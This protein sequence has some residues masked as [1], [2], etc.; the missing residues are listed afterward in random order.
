MVVLQVGY[1]YL[2][3]LTISQSVYICP[4][5]AHCAC[6]MQCLV[7]EPC[8]GYRLHVFDHIM[9]KIINSHSMLSYK[10]FISDTGVLH[11]VVI[12]DDKLFHTLQVHISFSKYVLHQVHDVL[13]HHAFART[14]QYM[15]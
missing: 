4:F 1:T 10:Y 5:Y 6:L 3:G 8:M 15:K 2:H 14:Y 11:R 13:G 12:G 9:L 7:L